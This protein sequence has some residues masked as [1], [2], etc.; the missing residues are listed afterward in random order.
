MLSTCAVLRWLQTHHF[1]LHLSTALSNILF[2]FA[3]LFPLRF[4]GNLTCSVLL[5]SNSLLLVQT[6]LTICSVASY[7]CWSLRGAEWRGL[8]KTMTHTLSMLDTWPWSYSISV[9]ACI[10]EVLKR[11]RCCCQSHIKTQCMLSRLAFKSNYFKLDKWH[12]LWSLKLN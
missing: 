9:I 3:L 5:C 12:F 10:A 11:V 7:S 4:Q 2:S 6:E 8:L 1:L